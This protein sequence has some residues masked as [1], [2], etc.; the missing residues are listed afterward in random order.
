MLE[1]IKTAL[2]VVKSFFSG[3][4]FDGDN[5]WGTYGEYQTNWDLWG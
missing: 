5:P 1:A 3:R 2:D 4:V